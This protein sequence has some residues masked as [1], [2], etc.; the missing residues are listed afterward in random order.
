MLLLDPHTRV[1]KWEYVLGP[2]SPGRAA[3]PGSPLNAPRLPTLAGI[4]G[5]GTIRVYRDS[6]S[7]DWVLG[8]YIY[9]SVYEQNLVELQSCKL[10]GLPA[11]S[12]MA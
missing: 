9:R 2:A 12:K 6:L 7:G 1:T 8:K 3:T 11:K 10:V 5:P 4:F